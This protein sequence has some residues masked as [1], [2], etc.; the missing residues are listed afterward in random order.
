MHNTSNAVAEGNRKPWL[1]PAIFSV[2]AFAAN[3]VFCRLALMNGDIDAQSFTAIRLSSGALFLFCL[4]KLRRPV[5]AIGGSW[6]GGLGLFLYA[7]LFSIAYVQ[8]GAGVGA[9]ILF[10]TVLM[11]SMAQLRL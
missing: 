4:I 3:S 10:G 6:Q 9:L 11:L 7:Y 8:F 2:L 5:Q 1:W